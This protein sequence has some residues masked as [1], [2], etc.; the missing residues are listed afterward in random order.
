MTAL[1]E[2]EAGGPLFSPADLQPS[3]PR[4]QVCG[5]FNPGAVALGDKVYL[6][7]R[8]AENARCEP[9]QISVPVMVDG[10][11][12]LRTFDLSDPEV[13]ASDSRYV[14][15]RGALLLSSLS[16][17]RLAISEDGV[18]F[19]L[20]PGVFM[21]PMEH[22][23]SY[24]IE[25]ARLTAIDGWIY[26]N[27]TAV[28][29]QGFCTA[30]A[31]TRDFEHVERL[32]IMFA[33]ENKDV[34]LIP[35]RIEGRYHCLHRPLNTL[36]GRHSIWYAHSDDLLAWGGHRCV[37]E[38]R[39]NAYEN[40]RV[41]G[42]A[43]CL[44]T[45]R[46]WLQIFHAADASHRYQ[47][48]AALFDLTQPWRLIA[49]SDAPIFTPE[50]SYETDGFFGQVVFCNGAVARGDELLLYYGAADEHTCVAC[51]SLSGILASMTPQS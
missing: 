7:L 3:D 30:L 8:V 48:F 15:H 25:D 50:E 17:F 23:E 18:A 34:C 40:G 51:G 12:T 43:P 49:R 41:G 16:H 5:V 20:Q 39:D 38:G 28:G 2:R 6:M 44:K 13:D 14:I 21:A 33:P 47:L 11:L 22:Y 32:G 31:R 37:L 29:P 9:G 35:E 27:Y 26:I 24:G 45:E 36:F 42:G 10:T 19:E 46:G 1:F 4:L